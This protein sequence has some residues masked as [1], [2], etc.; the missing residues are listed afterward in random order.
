MSDHDSRLSAKQLAQARQIARG[1]EIRN[2]ERL[3]RDYGGTRRRWW[4]MSSLPIYDP[5]NGW[6]ELH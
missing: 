4:K 2:V 1:S 5:P 3:V 6:L